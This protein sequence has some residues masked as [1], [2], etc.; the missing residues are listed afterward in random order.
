RLH[1]ACQWDA[2]AGEFVPWRSAGGAEELHFTAGQA[3][4]PKTTWEPADVHPVLSTN[5]SSTS[6]AIARVVVFPDHVTVYPGNTGAT[7]ILP[8][9]AVDPLEAQVV[10]ARLR[11]TAGDTAGSA[12][13]ELEKVR[14]VW[15]A[16][17]ASGA[18]QRSG[19]SFDEVKDGKAR[20]YVARY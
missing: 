9:L 8:E 10:T 5:W 12:Q 11:C 17:A 2:D 14:F 20:L 19:A 18:E 6:Y 3:S 7:L 16:A 4:V 13:Q 1:A 15:T